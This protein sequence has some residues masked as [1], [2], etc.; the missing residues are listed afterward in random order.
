MAEL[1][2]KIIPNVIDRMPELIQAT[3]DTTYMTV[4]SGIFSLLFGLIFGITLIVTRKGGIMENKGIYWVLD[5]I[6]NLFRSIPFLILLIALI[7]FTRIIVGVA[8]G[9]KGLILPLI[10]GTT[11]FFTRQIETA[12][13]QLDEGLIEAAQ[14]M[15]CS[16]FEIIFRVYL[17]ESIPALTRATAITFI[18]LLGLTAMAGTVGGGGLGDFAIRYGHQR[19]E[20]D[21]IYVSVII[22]LVMVSIIQS[23]GNIVVKKTTH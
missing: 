18:S 4:F 17:R 16:S 14:S 1:L 23:I 12:L 6:T 15:G 5:K 7:P 10:V 22:L 11:P 9:R 13:A 19:Q 21:I 20:L 2:H 3:K 8:I